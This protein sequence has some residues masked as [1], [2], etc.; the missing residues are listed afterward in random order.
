MADSFGKNINGRVTTG[1]RF[2]AT[3][4][5]NVPA[6]AVFMP[7]YSTSPLFGIAEYPVKSGELGAFATDGVFEF[8]KPEGWT[9]AAGQAVYYSPTS[10]VA[11]SFVAAASAAEGDVKI[12]FEVLCPGRTGLCVMLIPPSDL[13]P[14]AAAGGGGTT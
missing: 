8:T 10:A 2:Y 6:N 9:S 7:A 13:V 5:A 14:A 11:G 1:G 3:P 12:G 4:A